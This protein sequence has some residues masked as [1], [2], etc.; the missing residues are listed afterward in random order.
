M[1]FKVTHLA[2]VT[3]SSGFPDAYTHCLYFFFLLVTDHTLSSIGGYK[4]GRF[5]DT[6]YTKGSPNLLSVE[7]MTGRRAT[8]G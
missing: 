7:S 8:R 4:C 3:M 2:A 1:Q 6:Y 5:E